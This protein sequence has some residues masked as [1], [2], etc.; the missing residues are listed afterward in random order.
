MNQY[1]ID[2]NVHEDIEASKLNPNHNEDNK[3][4]TSQIKE[5][6]NHFDNSSSS[7]HNSLSKSTNLNE[8]KP[9]VDKNKEF[10]NK[11]RA[12]KI[13]SSSKLAEYRRKEAHDSR[14]VKRKKKSKRA[15]ERQ[16]KG[17]KGNRG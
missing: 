14:S 11:I 1:E 10:Q 13:S 8:F 9:V 5:I 3:D 15:R 17:Y 2:V 16:R 7:Q 12:F 4:S 6:E